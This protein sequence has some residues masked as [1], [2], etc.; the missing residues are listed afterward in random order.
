MAFQI[1]SLSGGGYLGLYT[2]SVLAELE[3]QTGRPILESFDLIAGT[4]IGGIIA[5]GLS[6][7]RSAND[8]KAAFLTHGERI[9]SAKPPSSGVF[10]SLLRTLVG[11][12]RARYDPLHLRA[13]IECI[14]GQN[15]KLSDLLRPTLVTAVN[16]TK[17]GPKVFKTG[18]HA[19]YVLDWRLS[20]VDVALATSAAP[21]YFP[22]HRIG[23]Q[24]YAD[25]GMFANSPDLIAVH[26][27]EQFLKVDRK[28]IYVLSIGTTTTEFSFSNSAGTNLG[29]FGWM[30]GER[31]PKVM[32]GSQ[33]ALTNDMMRHILGDRY[34]RVDRSQSR[35]QQS[36]LSLDCAS[37]SAKSD[38]MANAASSVAE[39][40]S[41]VNLQKMLSH[42]VSKSVFY[43]K[44]L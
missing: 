13:V 21:T 12:P 28:D 18:H 25:G 22:I 15:K 19:S 29:S 14:V 38:L 33:Q 41:N 37:Q 39:I 7:G 44:S 6:A 2:V 9:F 36:Q 24:M 30:R 35:E 16:L 40:S 5:L 11:M 32:I 1:L 8:I 20:V 10:N 43:N 27:A 17:G 26:E 23:E 31:L 4:S 42:V 34:L 3:R